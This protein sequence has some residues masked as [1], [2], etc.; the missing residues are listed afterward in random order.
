MFVPYIGFFLLGRVLPDTAAR[1]RQRY[2]VMAAVLATSGLW[3]EFVV[4]SM[5]GNDWVVGYAL[6]FFNPLMM[7]SALAIFAGVLAC[8]VP[9]PPESPVPAPTVSRGRGPGRSRSALRVLLSSAP[10]LTFGIYLIHPAALA[11]IGLVL[12]RSASTAPAV[13]LVALWAGGFATS[14][15]LVSAIRRV[16]ILRRVA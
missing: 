11:A 2:W 16:P 14:A 10:M 13:G 5:A 8:A 15:I 4:G 12:R 1:V 7:V 6:S 3:V 9:A